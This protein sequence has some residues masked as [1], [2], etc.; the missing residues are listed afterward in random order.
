MASP[1]PHDRS[2][3]EDV[4]EDDPVEQMI[5]RTGCAELHYAVQEC[6][7]EHQDWRACQSQ[8]QTF[9]DCM[10]NFQNAR[11]EQLRK[12]RLSSTQSAAS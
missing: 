8:V 9:K 3:K 6:M 2:R 5:S 1:S 4:D 7:A 12:Q 10:M 11:K